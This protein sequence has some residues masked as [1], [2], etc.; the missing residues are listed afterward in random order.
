MP[1]DQVY[2]MRDGFYCIVSGRTF[3]PWPFHQYA[4]AGMRTEQRRAERRGTVEDQMIRTV[5]HETHADGAVINLS[6]PIRV[7]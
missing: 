4:V 7:F 2:A 1:K 3:G 5:D 6:Q